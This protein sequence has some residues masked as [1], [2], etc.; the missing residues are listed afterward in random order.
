MSHCCVGLNT[1]NTTNNCETQR[2]ERRVVYSIMYIEVYSVP[3]P[4]YTLYTCEHNML[5]GHVGGTVSLDVT[6]VQ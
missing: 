3:G 4:V 6:S 5:S 2:E 1:R